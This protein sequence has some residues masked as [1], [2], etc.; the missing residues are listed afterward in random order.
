MEKVE[1]VRGW[2]QD[3]NAVTIVVLRPTV[4]ISYSTTRGEVC[5]AC[6]HAALR[7]S[8]LGTEGANQWRAGVITRTC[9]DCKAHWH[10]EGHS[11]YGTMRRTYTAVGVRVGG[12]AVVV[13]WCWRLLTQWCRST[14]RPT[15]ARHLREVQMKTAQANRTAMV[16][17]T[18]VAVANGRITWP[19]HCQKS[20]AADPYPDRASGQTHGGNCRPS[21]SS[22]LD[23]IGVVQGRAVTFDCKQTRQAS[24]PLRNILEHQLQEAREWEANGGNA[25]WLIEFRRFDLCYRVP[26]TGLTRLIELADEH[27]RKSIPH[28]WMRSEWVVRSRAGL[29]LDYL[30]GMYEVPKEVE[31]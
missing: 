11:P 16:W 3:G 8:W 23:Y 20:Q 12:G 7:V 22:G 19:G 6:L 4:Y 28:D 14:P 29:I 30:A 18:T 2:G 24:F 15:T 25:F 1:I 5:K 31:A 10:A 13:V 26:H 9:G 27:G 17:R 21:G